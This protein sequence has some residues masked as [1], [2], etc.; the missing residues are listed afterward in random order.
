MTVG[1]YGKLIILGLL[2]VGVCVLMGTHA[3]STDV[4]NPILTVVLG[5]VVGNGRTA[6]SGQAPSPALVAKNPT[7]IDGVPI[8]PPN[9]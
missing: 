2:V 4:G 8:T 6:Y 3:M 9:P 7:P 5:Y 1:D